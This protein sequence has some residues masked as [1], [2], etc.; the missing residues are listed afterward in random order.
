MAFS[1]ARLYSRRS[2]ITALLFRVFG[3]PARLDI[4]EQLADGGPV[5]VEKLAKNHPISLA[6]LSRHLGSLRGPDFVKYLE[7]HPHILYSIEKK[8]ILRARKYINAFFD[9]LE[10]L[11]AKRERNESYKNQG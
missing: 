5:P 1:K 11:M 2:R 3:H 8:N 6:T 7:D 9:R 4:L 10:E